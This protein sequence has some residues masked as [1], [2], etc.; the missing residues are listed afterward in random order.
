MFKVICCPSCQGEG[1]MLMVG[2]PGKFSTALESYHP[3]EA[4]VRCD[5]CA[6]EGEIEVCV[7][8]LEQLQIVDGIETCACAAQQLPKAA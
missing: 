2:R 3:S 8:C 6:G 4:F 1:Y 5:E 7:V